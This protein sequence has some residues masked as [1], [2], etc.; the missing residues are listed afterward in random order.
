MTKDDLTKKLEEAREALDRAE[1][2]VADVLL[3]LDECGAEDDADSMDDGA[4][5]VFG[6]VR[7]H[8]N[9]VEIRVTWMPA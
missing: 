2:A 7:D 3:A 8:I 4:H 5:D 6:V 9:N 1:S